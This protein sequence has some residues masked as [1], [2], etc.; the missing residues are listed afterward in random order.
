M[1]EPV[2][3]REFI[4]GIGGR[5]TRNKSEAYIRAIMQVEGRSN[6]FTARHMLVGDMAFSLS[7]TELGITPPEASKAICQCL[8]EMI[9]RAEELGR[10]NAT[11]D[12]VFQREVWVADVVGRD[13]GA[14]QHIGRHRAES[15]RGYLPRMFFRD[16][17]WRERQAMLRLVR[18][19]VDKAGPVLEAYAPVY[20]HLQHA[21]YTTLGEY[22]LGFA[23]N[24]IDYIER[25]EQ[26]DRRLD[27][28]PPA[29]SGRP[30]LVQ[31]A[32]RAS[33][34][35]GFTRVQLLRQ[36]GH[37]TEEQFSEPFFAL[38]APAVVLARMAEDLRL[39]MSSEF[40]FFEL[41]DEHA[42]I[43]SGLPQKKNPFGLQTVIGGA[44]VGAGRLASQLA[45]NI[46][47]SGEA[48]TVYHMGSLFQYAN[49]VIN[50]TTFMA[51]VIEKGEF[52][53]AE[54]DRKSKWGYAGASEAMDTLIFDHGL[55][56]RVAHHMLGAIVRAAVEGADEKTLLAKL[57]PE[58]AEH[59]EIDPQRILGILKGEILLDTAINIAGART[60]HREL[61]ERLRALESRPWPNAMAE[62]A[63]RVQDEAR[64]FCAARA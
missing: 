3:T 50:W 54:L 17:L 9:P 14:W 43:S 53:L 52:N 55:P 30:V 21:G 62:A 40:A 7:A 49:D 61:D 34:R 32:E 19:L 35:L 38:V 13:V 4:E 22:L 25:F 45:S 59:P 56:Q 5:L 24:L 39:W 48:D 58:L 10:D 41:S 12:I 36:Q 37:L 46:A 51:E 29:H 63:A 11:G 20:H 44:A 27:F 28:A 42:S 16:A 57:K 26:I 2:S 47:L 18:T 15:L 31:L 60:V 23:G 6:Q 1:S 8:L 33:Q 64:R